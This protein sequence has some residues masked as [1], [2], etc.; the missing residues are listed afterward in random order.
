MVMY[1][2]RSIGR[3]LEWLRKLVAYADYL[4]FQGDG[5]ITL[6]DKVIIRRTE[7]DE[8]DNP[9]F[10]FS[11]ES[12]L[13]KELRERIY[14]RIREDEFRRLCYTMHPDHIHALEDLA[15]FPIVESSALKEVISQVHIGLIDLGMATRTQDLAGWNDEGTPLFDIKIEISPQGRGF[16]HAYQ[17]KNELED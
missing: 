6:H 12:D 15:D 7:W 3:M 2:G 16:L 11:N 5:T 14:L 8:Y 9:K 1:H 4:I 17:N 10:I 13:E